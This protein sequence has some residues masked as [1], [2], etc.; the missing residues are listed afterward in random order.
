MAVK[1]GKVLKSFDQRR[2]VHYVCFTPLKKMMDG[3]RETPATSIFK[4]ASK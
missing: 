2:P 1:R 4:A 3:N